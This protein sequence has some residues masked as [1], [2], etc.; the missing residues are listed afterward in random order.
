MSQDEPRQNSSKSTNGLCFCFKLLDWFSWLLLNMT[1]CAYELLVTLYI[2][3]I[4]IRHQFERWRILNG[5]ILPRCS[6]LLAEMLSST[7]HELLSCYSISLV[8]IRR[9]AFCLLFDST[10]KHAA[11][12][13]PTGLLEVASFRLLSASHF[14]EL[15][16]EEHDGLLPDGSEAAGRSCWKLKGTFGRASR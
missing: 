13:K 4:Y 16:D 10:P 7:A 2:Q 3:Y 9:T 6:G 12:M 14:F 5:S 8:S 1:S 15:M 11:K